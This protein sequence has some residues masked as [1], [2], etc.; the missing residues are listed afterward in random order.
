MQE[1]EIVIRIRFPKWPKR[2]W[3][4]AIGCL[5]MVAGAAGY[6]YTFAPFSLTTPTAGTP[7]SASA[8]ATNY[9]AIQNKV[10]ELQGYIQ[11]PFY[12]NPTT[13]QTYSLAA[14][15][16]GE[17][18]ATAGAVA[19]GSLSGIPATKSLCQKACGGSA[20]AHMCNT[21]EVQ[22]FIATGGAFPSSGA[23]YPTTAGWYSSG[24]WS[25]DGTKVIFDCASWTDGTATN[26]G[27]AAF[28]KDPAH[29]ATC[30]ELLP[31]LCCD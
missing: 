19:D 15:Y 27:P 20:T 1:K 6:A 5:M 24:L 29:N 3:L 7:V 28:L 14:T 31:I 10:A 12:T 8:I 2:R 21:E 26:T 11:K 23:T 30:N 18:A 22:R 4:V 25:Y 13:G 17:T 16:C 9:T